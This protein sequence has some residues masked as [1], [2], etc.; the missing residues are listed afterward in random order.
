MALAVIVAC[1]ATPVKIAYCPSASASAKTNTTR[2]L[3]VR[4]SPAT[5]AVN[6]ALAQMLIS[7]LLALTPILEFLILKPALAIAFQE[8]G[9]ASG[10][11]NLAIIP[12]SLV[13]E[14]LPPIA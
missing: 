11:A 1:R 13:M 4:V 9:E 8:C 14:D 10:S 7:V 12:V 2:L 5:R 6:H 3:M